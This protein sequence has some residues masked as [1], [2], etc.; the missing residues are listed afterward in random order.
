[1]HE[2]VLKKANV[3]AQV[4][5]LSMKDLPSVVSLHNNTIASLPEDK[6]RF[7]L[8]QTED[9]FSNLLSELTGVMVGLKVKGELIAQIALVGELSIDETVERKLLTKNNVSFHHVNSEDS[10]VIVKSLV[11]NPDWRGNDLCSHIIKE[12][13]KTPL[14]LSSDHLLTQISADNECS[15]K[16]FL[17]Y[18]FGIVAAGY[19]PIDTLPRLIFQK[20]VA[21]FNFVP[22][23]VAD[24][25]D[26]V[27]DFSAIMKLT[28]RQALVGVLED[29]LHDSLSF[30]EVA[31]ARSKQAF[32]DIKIA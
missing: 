31:E 6:K 3:T 24:D 19:D 22:N 5:I 28:E 27:A 10:I 32:S 15:V 11:S 12:S 4:D 23:V 18:G 29:N 1:M 8:P 16:K 13:F 25:V 26:P 2:I 20:P 30:L 17:G 14:V 7:V 21:G 9:Y